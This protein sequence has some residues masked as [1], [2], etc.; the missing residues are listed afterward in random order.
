MPS[1]LILRGQP[2]AMYQLP[3]RPRGEGPQ[4]QH[5]LVTPLFHVRDCAVLQCPDASQSPATCATGRFS[6]GGLQYCQ[7][8][9]PGYLCSP[10]ST[11]AAPPADAVPAGTYFD[12]LENSGALAQCP[13]GTYG[14]TAGGT[15]LVT[16]CS[17]CVAGYYCPAGSTTPSGPQPYVLCPPGS[18]CPIGT[19]SPTQYLCPAGTFSNATGAYDSSSCADCTEVIVFQI[20]SVA[21]ASHRVASD[22]LCVS[23]YP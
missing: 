21:C 19:A 9:A 3:R 8:C 15:S 16:A 5:V 17:A 1:R 12:P 10:G 14:S 7:P 4:V 23:L 2:G 13:A 20:L 11:S 6:P 22:F 18:Y